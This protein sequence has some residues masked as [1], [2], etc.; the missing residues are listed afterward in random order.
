[1]PDGAVADLPVEDEPIG[2][3]DDRIEDLGVV[4]READQLAGQ[5]GRLFFSSKVK[6]GRPLMNSPMSSARC[7]SSRL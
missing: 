3:D 2:D 1:M 5:P 6:T 4:L 7:V